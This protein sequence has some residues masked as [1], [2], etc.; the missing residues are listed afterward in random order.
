MKT[1]H[2]FSA[3]EDANNPSKR[4]TNSPEHLGGR[5][6]QMKFSSYIFLLICILSLSSCKKEIVSKDIYGVW[7][8]Q[9]QSSEDGPQ[10]NKLILD[11]EDY[12]WIDPI[13]NDTIFFSRKLRLTATHCC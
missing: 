5:V 9:K 1:R 3:S 12:N 7:V 13:V 4:I 2:P 8:M 11:K 10:Y 6:K